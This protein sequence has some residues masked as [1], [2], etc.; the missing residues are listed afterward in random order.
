M[1]RL[2]GVGDRASD[3]RCR[4]RCRRVRCDAMLWKSG[5]FT[6]CCLCVNRNSTQT[7]CHHHRNKRELARITRRRFSPFTLQNR[8]NPELAVVGDGIKVARSKAL[9]REK[10]INSNGLYA[11][12]DFMKG[13]MITLYDGTIYV[14]DPQ[15]LEDNDL[16]SHAYTYVERADQSERILGIKST[17][18]GIRGRGG[19]SLANSTRG[20]QVS[21]N[22]KIYSQNHLD[23]VSPH[24]TNVPYKYHSLSGLTGSTQIGLV[25]LV[26][27]TNIRRGEEILWKY[28]VR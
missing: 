27:T 12:W 13:D 11:T 2:P 15:K 23:Q 19:A 21:P 1:H 6:R 24:R 7:S 22:S 17:D 9:W 14:G 10:R 25:V 18:D 5:R 3:T 20:L 16:V 4:V 26:A 28:K 8:G